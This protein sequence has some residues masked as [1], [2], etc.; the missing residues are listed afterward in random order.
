MSH[1]PRPPE[2]FV[3][4]SLG[5]YRVPAALRA[6]GWRIRT[7]HEVF[8]TRDQEVPD[9]EW[10]ELCSREGWI[11]LTADRRLRYRP[12][13]V[14]V[15]RTHGVRAFVLVGGSL[16]ADEQVARLEHNR[17]RI[18]AASADPGPF[19]YSVHATTITRVFRP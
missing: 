5:R 16:R 4:R 13:E 17:E 14:D 18:A 3:D 12:D 15:I 8:G 7:H 11:V 9:V 1:F 10:L 6:A 19:V 2:F